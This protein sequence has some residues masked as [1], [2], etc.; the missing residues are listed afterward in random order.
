MRKVLVI[1][2]PG[3]GKSTFARALAAATGL[4]LV[5]LDNLFWNTDHTTVGREEF[6]RRLQEVLG[7]NAWIIDGNY[8]STLELRLQHC[9]TVFFLDYPVEHC[10]RGL[11]QRLGQPRSDMPWVEEEL[12]PE[13]VATVK[14]FPTATRPDIVKLLQAH[15]N[16]QVHRLTMPTAPTDFEP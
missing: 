9:D 16:V 10:L 2:S 4:P 11:E 15:P 3:S 12:D 8:P 7:Q 6:R 14:E 13:L 1:G 5:H